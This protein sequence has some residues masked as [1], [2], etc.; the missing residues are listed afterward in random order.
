MEFDNNENTPKSKEKTTS[1][2]IENTPVSKEKSRK[3]KLRVRPLRQSKK[4][5]KYARKKERDRLYY[6]QRRDCKLEYVL[7]NLNDK[8][9]TCKPKA[10][11]VFQ[12]SNKKNYIKQKVNGRTKI[13]FLS[14]LTGKYRRLNK[15]NV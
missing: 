6:I 3:K 1:E 7:I 8:D 5:D 11:K 14:D 4:N 2:N 13:F 12:N 9:P 10:Y 15:E